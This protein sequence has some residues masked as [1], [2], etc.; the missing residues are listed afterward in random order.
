MAPRPPTSGLVTVE[1]QIRIG[2]LVLLT[3]ASALAQTELEYQLRWP[4]AASTTDADT[5]RS[6][7]SELEPQS[8]RRKTG[9]EKHEGVWCRGG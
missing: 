4:D 6:G 3:G 8:E 9:E 2:S 5:N 7:G 1:I